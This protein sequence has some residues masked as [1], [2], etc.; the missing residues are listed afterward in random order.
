MCSPA[1]AD[2]DS[3][4]STFGRR[5]E[6]AKSYPAGV[7]VYCGFRLWICEPFPIQVSFLTNLNDV[8]ADER[9]AS[10]YELVSLSG[11]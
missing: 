5:P 2:F 6:P 7:R 8:L 3:A 4:A 11:T 10:S 9:V 1:A